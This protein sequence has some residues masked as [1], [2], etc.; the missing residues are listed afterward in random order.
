MG[1]VYYAQYLIFFERARSE[2][3]RARGM[4]YALVEKRGL[5]LPVRE[6]QCRYKAPAHYDD[7]ILIHAAISEWGR[8]SI[9]FI[10]EIWN[11]DKTTLLTVGSTQHAVVNPQSRPIPVPDWFRKLGSEK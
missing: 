2:F 9:R 11:E 10:Y 5:I 4:S 6:V 8:A 3:I 1:I 7:L